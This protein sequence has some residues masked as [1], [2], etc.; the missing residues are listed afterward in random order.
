MRRIA[1]VEL[2]KQPRDLGH[3]VTTKHPH[4]TVPG[5]MSSFDQVESAL[6]KACDG[7]SPEIMK[8]QI[9]TSSTRSNPFESETN[10]TGSEREHETAMRRLEIATTRLESAI[11]DLNSPHLLKRFNCS[12]RQRNVA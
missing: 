11:I 3:H 4:I 1:R 9:R 10:C 2:D 12:A 7:F 6:D 5:N 8:A